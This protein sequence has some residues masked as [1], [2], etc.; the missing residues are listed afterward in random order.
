MLPIAF[1]QG[2]TSRVSLESL[3]STV[4]F[5]V[6]PGLVPAASVLK[7]HILLDVGVE[8]VWVLMSL[9]CRSTQ[10]SS[11]KT[12]VTRAPFQCHSQLGRK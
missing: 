10:V 6:R 11:Q 9:V 4:C 12:F 8:A 5:H 2:D 7:D 1:G 3:A